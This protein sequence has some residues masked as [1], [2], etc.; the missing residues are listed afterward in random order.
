LDGSGYPKGLAG[1]EIIRG[2]R[3]I[4]VADVI[5]AM[6]S[7]RPYRSSRGLPAALRLIEEERGRRLDPEIV[8]ACLRLFREG[9]FSTAVAAHGADLADDMASTD[10]GWI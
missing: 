3:I 10:E 4:A 1:A 9:R 2:A 6:S 7:P 8:D 5:D